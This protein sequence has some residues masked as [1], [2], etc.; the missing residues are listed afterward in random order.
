MMITLNTKFSSVGFSI[1]EGARA[2]QDDEFLDPTDT[3]SRSYSSAEVVSSC[4]IGTGYDPNLKISG[5]KVQCQ[6]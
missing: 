4:A 3:R 5:G 6:V 1:T 2:L